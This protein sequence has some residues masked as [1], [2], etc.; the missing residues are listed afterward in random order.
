MLMEE[1][2]RKRPGFRLEY[3]IELVDIEMTNGQGEKKG[4]CGKDGRC[5]PDNAQ[6]KVLSDGFHSG[7]P[8][9]CSSRSRGGF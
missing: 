9:R 8:I 7:W 1:Q 2:R 5:S 6:P 3:F 4:P